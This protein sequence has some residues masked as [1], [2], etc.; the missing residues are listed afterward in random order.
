[1]AAPQQHPS[2]LSSFP[3][4]FFFSSKGNRYKRSRA[5]WM[6]G[7]VLFFLIYQQNEDCYFY[8][9]C[10]LKARSERYTPRMRSPVPS[11]AKNYGCSGRTYWSELPRSGERAW[12]VAHEQE[13]REVCPG[14]EEVHTHT[15]THSIVRDIY[16]YTRISSGCCCTKQPVIFT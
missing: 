8:M 14:M 3:Q 4:V 2:T 6:E 16:I 1:M 7:R 9:W 13:R 12:V 5:E 11:R 15:H 10:D